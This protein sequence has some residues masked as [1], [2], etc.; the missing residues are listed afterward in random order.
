MKCFLFVLLFFDLCLFIAESTKANLNIIARFDDSIQ[1]VVVIPAILAILLMIF[2]YIHYK[3]YVRG[4]GNKMNYIYIGKFF[5][6]VT[7]LFT[8]LFFNIVLYFE[9]RL[10]TLTYISIGSMIISYVGSIFI[11]VFWIIRWKAWTG[12]YSERLHEYL[13]KYSVVLMG[14][15]IISNFYVAID[16]SRSRLFYLNAFYFP[17]KRKEHRMLEKYRFFN[18][19]MLENVIQILVQIVYLMNSD[20]SQINNIVFYSMMFSVFGIFLSIMKFVTIDD[21]KL[22]RIYSLRKKFGHKS[23]IDG[24]FVIESNKFEIYHV[25]SHRNV[26]TCLIRFLWDQID[27]QIGGHS[28]IKRNDI[29]LS[30]DVYHIENNVILKNEL[31]IYFLFEI[32]H[33]EDV[34]LANGVFNIFATLLNQKELKNN[35]N[36]QDY[37]SQNSSNNNNNNNTFKNHG[38]KYNGRVSLNAS[39]TNLQMSI[40]A[41]GDECDEGNGNNNQVGELN[42]DVITLT[43]NG[44]DTFLKMLTK[45]FNIKDQ[46]VKFG[47]V[48]SHDQLKRTASRN[49]M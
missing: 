40:I 38:K 28:S 42:S 7:D 6:Q 23:V 39:T 11:C 14:I 49:V 22:T 16:L 29:S 48:A 35:N 15:T 25:Y 5:F 34:R 12:K 36:Y 21:G 18:I 37:S 10:Y 31:K 4:K 46:Y 24:N 13:S 3:T 20:S 43:P 30:C 1:Y 44:K 8:D 47:N 41:A 9:N 32:Y 45:C 17:L 26:E 2:S 19:V 33:S 27:V